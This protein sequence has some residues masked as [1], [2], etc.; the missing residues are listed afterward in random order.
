[1]KRYIYESMSLCD[2]LMLLVPKKDGPWRMCV[3]CRAVNKIIVKYRHPIIM[4]DELYVSCIFSKIV[5]KSGYHQIRMKES[6]E[7]KT[8]FK[9]SMVCMN[10]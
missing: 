5:L 2:V 10:G 3:S 8:T 4:L 1:M 6:D 9:L 7:W